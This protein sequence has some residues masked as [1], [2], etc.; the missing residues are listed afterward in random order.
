M[1]KTVLAKVKIYGGMG[2]SEDLLNGKSLE[3]CP[4]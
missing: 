3:R 2:L 4:E 1:F